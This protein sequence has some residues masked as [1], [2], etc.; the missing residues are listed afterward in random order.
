MWSLSLD[1]HAPQ[2][3]GNIK[4]SGS[5]RATFS[6]DGKKND[7]K[8]KS[9]GKQLQFYGTILSTVPVRVSNVCWCSPLCRQPTSQPTNHPSILKSKTLNSSAYK[10]LKFITAKWFEGNM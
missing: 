7:F 9:I 8:R 10:L 1:P 3:H 5:N 4:Q 2:I 6:K